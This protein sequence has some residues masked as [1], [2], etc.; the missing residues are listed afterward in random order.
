M[1]A[2]LNQIDAL[3]RLLAAF[4]EAD[5]AVVLALPFAWQEGWHHPWQDHPEVRI[6]ALRQCNRC[7]PMKSGVE[8][9][10][11]VPVAISVSR[12]AGWHLHP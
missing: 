3:A 8:K 9:M 5:R 12:P 11:R 6:G 1:A 7:A 2:D 4:G 10:S